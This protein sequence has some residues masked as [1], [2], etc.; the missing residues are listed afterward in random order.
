M[1]RL[2]DDDVRSRLRRMDERGLSKRDL[3]SY[4]AVEELTSRKQSTEIPDILDR[5]GIPFDPALEARRRDRSAGGPGIA[6][7][8]AGR[9]TSC[10]LPT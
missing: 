4:S 1:R 2:V 10:W 9:S 3:Y 5:M 7:C 6:T 8:C